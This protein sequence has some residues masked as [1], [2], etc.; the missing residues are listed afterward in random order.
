MF[1]PGTRLQIEGFDDVVFVVEDGGGVHGLA[2]TCGSRLRVAR[3]FGMHRRLVA[4]L[5][6]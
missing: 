3:S 4:V 2:S 1:P 5:P 6:S